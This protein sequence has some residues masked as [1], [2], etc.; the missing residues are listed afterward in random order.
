[1]LHD[2]LG[3]LVSDCGK[4]LAAAAAVFAGPPVGSDAA[5]AQCAASVAAMVRVAL[6]SEAPSG[7]TCKKL[8]FDYDVLKI[9][10]LGACKRIAANALGKREV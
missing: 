3:V 7:R 8:M 2:A 6:A 1:M 4:V 10:H 9:G 5:L